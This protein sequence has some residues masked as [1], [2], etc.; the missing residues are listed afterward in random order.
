MA[1]QAEMTTM[2]PLDG[3][4]QRTITLQ[5]AVADLDPDTISYDD[6]R[7]TLYGRN[8]YAFWLH[9]YDLQQF[10][11]TLEAPPSGLVI[12]RTDWP[13]AES[14]GALPYASEVRVNETIWVLPGEFQDELSRE[15]QLC[16]PSLVDE[17]LSDRCS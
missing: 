17:Q 14:I 8:G 3:P 16:Q 15:G 10:D 4:W 12:S 6:H 1:W 9:E 13:E 5:N 7:L 2:R 11:S